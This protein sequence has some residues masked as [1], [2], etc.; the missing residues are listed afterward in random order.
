MLK[1]IDSCYSENN[2]FLLYEEM[3]QEYLV[4]FKEITEIVYLTKS[5]F[6]KTIENIKR[7]DSILL[8]S[9]DKLKKLM[10]QKLLIKN[11]IKET[12]INV[13]VTTHNMREK[14]YIK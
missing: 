13:C 11:F 2:W 4:R 7:N 14:L 3:N 8:D 12:V 6:L 10:K 9:Y 1:K 5:Q